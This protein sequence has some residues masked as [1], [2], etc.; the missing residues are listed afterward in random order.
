M[1]EDDMYRPVRTSKYRA[2]IHAL[3][4]APREGGRYTGPPELQQEL[5][6]Q[7]RELFDDDP[8]PDVV[9]LQHDDTLGLA[10]DLGAAHGH[11]SIG[12]YASALSSLMRPPVDD[13]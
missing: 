12:Q 3:E 6:E 1:H 5:A 2:M 9:Y 8:G 13:N 4:E 10:D 11:W 7:M